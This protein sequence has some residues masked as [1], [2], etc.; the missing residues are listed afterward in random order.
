MQINKFINI[1][2]TLGLQVEILQNQLVDQQLINMLIPASAQTWENPSRVITTTARIAY[3]MVMYKRGPNP[4]N[5]LPDGNLQKPAQANEFA[6]K[7]QCTNWSPMQE[8]APKVIQ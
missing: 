2:S 6:P 3:Q 5:V 7:W 1:W 4:A 8:R